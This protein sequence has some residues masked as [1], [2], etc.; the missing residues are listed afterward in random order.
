MAL[1]KSPL[2]PRASDRCPSSIICNS[3]LCASG[4]AFSTSSKTTIEYGRRR[5]ASVSCPASSYPTYPGGA[6]TSR[7]T[8]W[9]S[10][11]SDISNWI[12]ASSLPNMKRARALVSSVLPTPVGPRNMNEP[13]GRRG[14]FNPARARRTALEIAW[15]ASSCPM[16]RF[17]RS[18]SICSNRSDSAWAI[19]ITGT[20][21]HIATTSAISSEVTVGLLAR[22]QPVRRNSS[23]RSSPSIR[24]CRSC[25][26]SARPSSRAS[27]WSFR[28]PLSWVISSLA[29]LAAWLLY[30]RTREEDSSIKS[31]AL[32]GRNRSV[33]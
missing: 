27:T 6:P 26:S 29:V 12:R 3:I 10:M 21:V 22:S 30:M 31:M 25:P 14:S 9:R 32:S 20:P 8:V 5:R 11:N 1:R 28:R 7:L 33:T 15:M 23:W 4:W 13:I 17:C 19:C 16:M 24:S 2:R 18:P